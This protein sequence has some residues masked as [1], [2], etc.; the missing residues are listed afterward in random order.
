MESAKVNGVKIASIEAD[1]AHHFIHAKQN[2][3]VAHGLYLEGM[4]TSAALYLLEAISSLRHLYTLAVASQK[5]TA[6]K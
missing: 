3:E 1:Y 5:D 2:I 6:E 4:S